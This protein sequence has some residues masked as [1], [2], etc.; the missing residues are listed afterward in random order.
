MGVRLRFGDPALV[1]SVSDFLRLRERAVEEVDEGTVE[2][3]L[4]HTLHELQARME[5]DL[6]LRVCVA[7]PSRAPVEAVE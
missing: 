3:S 4:P 7:Q 5:L 1:E 6:Y 2:I